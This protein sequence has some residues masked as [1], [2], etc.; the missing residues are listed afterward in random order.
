MNRDELI[1][2]V[3]QTAGIADH[4]ANDILFAIEAAGFAIVPVV[5][6]EDC[7]KAL[8][9]DAYTRVKIYP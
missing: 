7:D 5:A 8:S 4:K 2:L 3:S 9:I 1:A 6:S